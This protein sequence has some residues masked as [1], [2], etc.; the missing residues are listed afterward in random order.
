MHVDNTGI[1][2][3]ESHFALKGYYFIAATFRES[4]TLTKLDK[5][6]QKFITM[7]LT[8][9]QGKEYERFSF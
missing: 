9:A 1:Y 7:I 5:T 2:V 8:R 3:K 6:L 4:A